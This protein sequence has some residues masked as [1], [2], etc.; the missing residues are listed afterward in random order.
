M[1]RADLLVLEI[2]SIW[3]ES[4]VIATASAPAPCNGCCQDDE[5]GR[6]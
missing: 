5:T 1:T 6:R 3:P 2:F 4:I